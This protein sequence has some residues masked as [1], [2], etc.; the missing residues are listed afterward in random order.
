MVERKRKL[1]KQ[2]KERIE[3]ENKLLGLANNKRM[4]GRELFFKQANLFTDAEDAL[5]VYEK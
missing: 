5:E 1:D 4:S 3:S 2:R